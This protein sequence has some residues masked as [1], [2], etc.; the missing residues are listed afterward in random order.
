MN[1]YIS[2][3]ENIIG[4]LLVRKSERVSFF[5]NTLSECIAIKFNFDFAG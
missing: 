1:I 5:T 2:K 3:M 4:S